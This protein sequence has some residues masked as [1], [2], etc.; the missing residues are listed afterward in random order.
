MLRGTLII[1]VGLTFWLSGIVTSAS[2]RIRLEGVWWNEVRTSKKK[3]VE[4]NYAMQLS[5]IRSLHGLE[6][7]RQPRGVL[8]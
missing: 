7:A 6:D 1:Y 8:V 2:K 4:M 3:Y 5:Q